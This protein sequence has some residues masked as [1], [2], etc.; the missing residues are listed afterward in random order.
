MSGTH[1]APT[2]VPCMMPNSG[3]AGRLAMSTLVSVQANSQDNT[4]PKVY[5]EAVLHY[6]TALSLV[7]GVS[8]LSTYQIQTNSLCVQ[9]QP[10]QQASL[11]RIIVQSPH[12][13]SLLNQHSNHDEQQG[14]H[15]GSATYGA[16]AC[17]HFPFSLS[18]V[19]ENNY[20]D[21]SDE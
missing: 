10:V 15:A 6:R 4:S 13:P 18:P 12:S 14:T 11:Y 20:S 9:W 19:Q 8:R 3:N 2:I 17:V 16:Q 21:E 7:L 1:L 5:S